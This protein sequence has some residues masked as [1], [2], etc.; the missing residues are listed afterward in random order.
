MES[1]PKKETAKC[2]Y[3]DFQPESG[4]DSRVQLENHCKQVHPEEWNRLVDS[5]LTEFVHRKNE[6]TP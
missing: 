3:C 4:R 1:L 5:F 6:T 2:S